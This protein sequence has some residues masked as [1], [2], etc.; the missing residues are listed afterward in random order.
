MNALAHC[1]EA[2]YVAGRNL[3]G[4]EHALEGTRLNRTTATQ[5]PEAAV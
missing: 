3:T 2:L 5:D 4:H 1:A